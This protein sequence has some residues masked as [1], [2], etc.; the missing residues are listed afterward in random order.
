MARAFLLLLLATF[1]PVSTAG[2]PTQGDESM[3][4]QKRPPK[5]TS[6]NLEDD[7]DQDSNKYVYNPKEAKTA[8]DSMPDVEGQA[9]PVPHWHACRFQAKAGG[10]YDLRPMMRL[11]ATLEDDWVHKDAT[12]SG[13][14]YYLNIC[15]NTMQVPRAC[16]KLAKKDPS[17]AYQ[18]GSNGH[19]FYLGTLK[20]FK[21]KPIDSA[22]PSKG[23][24][25]AYQNGAVSYTHLTLP[26]KR[27]V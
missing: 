18:I 17:P 2:S 14:S 27:I 15:A 8:A 3:L 7:G 9:P 1:A 25:L 10:V 5:G 20:T 21:W 16:K 4:L 24:I 6:G 26:T 11:A 23:M 22:V 12:V 19:C 13:V